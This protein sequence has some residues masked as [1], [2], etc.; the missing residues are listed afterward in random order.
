MTRLASG[1]P[2][3]VSVV[4]LDGLVLARSAL[5][6]SMNY[7]S[8]VVFASPVAVT[9]PL[10]KRAMLDA[11]ADHIVP[12]RRTSIRPPTAAEIAATAVVWLPIVEA[13]AKV[14]TGP[15]KDGPADRQIPVWAGTIPLRLV[16]GAPEPDADVRL[17]VPE[18]VARWPLR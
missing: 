2:V 13:S 17:P 10:R 11:A 9:D 1:D 18:H 16:P 5:F 3:C 4:L 7:R 8:V 12:G 6:H 15:P 14:R